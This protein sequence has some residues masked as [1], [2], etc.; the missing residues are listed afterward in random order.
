MA[1]GCKYVCKVSRRYRVISFFMAISI[2]ITITLFHHS[3][4]GMIANTLIHVFMY[5]YYFN[6]SL[7]RS[8]WFKKYITSG[9]IIQF[10]TSFILS[11]PYLY[12]HFTNNCKYGFKAFLFSMFCNGTFLILFIR[13]FRK[14]YT[15]DPSVK[16]GNAHAEKK[17][18]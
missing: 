6:A 11:V 13:F 9:Q 12:F 1:G 15:K 17:S 8:V 3:S 4:I 5:Y 10:S 16:Q 7:G 14:T 18:L 2:N